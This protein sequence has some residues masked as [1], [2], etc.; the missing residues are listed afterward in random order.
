LIST[1]T[2]FLPFPLYGIVF[3]AAGLGLS[4]WVVALV[5]G[6]GS[7]LGELTGYFIGEGGKAVIQQ[8]DHK[9]FAFLDKFVKFFTKYGFITIVGTSLLPFPFDFIGILSGMSNYDLRKFLLAT[10]IGKTGKILLIAYAGYFAAP[11]IEPL[12]KSVF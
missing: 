11:Y 9:R 10:F 2:L 7:A 3:F 6:A 1:S 12:V 8:K 4:P 5:A